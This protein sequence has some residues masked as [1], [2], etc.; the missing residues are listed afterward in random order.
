M[1]GATM[2]GSPMRGMTGTSPIVHRIDPTLNIA[3][4]TAGIK[5]RCSEF[6]MPISAAASATIVRNGNMMRVSITVSSSLPG[7]AAYFAAN[8]V[9]MGQAK[10]RPIA[11][12]ASVA[13]TRALITIL[14]RRHARSR[15]SR[16]SV[17]VN[18][19]TNAALI[20]P[21]AN[22]S[23]TRFGILKATL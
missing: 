12:T 14:P 4:E 18:V 9:V 1:A 6:S 13:N 15:P 23:R 10:T 2:R 5:N 3:G 8:A 17:R 20:A 21:S 11:T 16:V 7:T 19:G 22:R